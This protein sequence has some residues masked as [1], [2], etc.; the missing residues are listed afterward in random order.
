V[1]A[2]NTPRGLSADVVADDDLDFSLVRELDQ[3]GGERLRRDIE[4]DFPLEV[5]GE[6]R[7]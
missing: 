7:Q 6:S 2:R 3:R 1:S 4:I 5:D